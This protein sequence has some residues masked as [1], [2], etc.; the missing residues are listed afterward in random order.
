MAAGPQPGLVASG[1]GARQPQGPEPRPGRG[2]PLCPNRR[3]GQSPAE[4]F[5]WLWLPF[6]EESTQ[7]RHG[8][9]DKGPSYDGVLAGVTIRAT[10]G[11]P[12]TQGAE[13]GL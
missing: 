12:L 10:L 11:A 1:A 6:R 13:P 2:G 5:L 8:E 9:E 4:S 3:A 7:D